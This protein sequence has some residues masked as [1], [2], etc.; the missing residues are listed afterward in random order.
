MSGQAWHVRSAGRDVGL[1]PLPVAYVVPLR[2]DHP[3]DGE[4]LSYLRW[5]AGQ[6]D[7]V[8]VI[9][10]SPRDVAL[11]DRHALSGSA[12]VLRPDPALGGANGKVGSVLTGLARAEHDRVVVAD[13]DVR[14]P[15]E[16][17]EGVV[18][19][20]DGAEAVFPQ[21]V[22]RPRP[23]H[24]RWDTARILVHRALGHDMPGTVAVRRSFLLACGGYD[25]N[26]LFE[27][28]ELARTIEAGGGRVLHARGLYIDRRPPSTRH[29]RSQRMR[30]A[31]DEFARPSRMALW[32]A[33][34]PGTIWALVR[35]RRAVPIGIAIASIA[36]AEIGRR[37]DGGRRAFTPTDPLWAPLWLTERA[38][39]AWLAVGA[40][41]TGGARYRGA[42]IAQ[43]ATPMRRLRRAHAH[44]T[45]PVGRVRELAR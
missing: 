42:R 2:G 1:P 33:V 38:I 3:L 14:Y 31:Y 40:R 35:G 6:V 4:A 41:L 18:A 9:D 11:A 39:C 43:A 19:L 22:F 45:L 30:Q 28:L 13:D 5:L 34:L 27:N 7:R 36:L 23:W 32:L 21:N 10:G 24:A 25:A 8:L 20:L 26:V 16:G 15:R 17:L 29:F 37:V 12:E 44:Q